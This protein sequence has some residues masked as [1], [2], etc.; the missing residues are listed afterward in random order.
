[1]DDLARPA[2][3]ERVEFR[4]VIGDDQDFIFDELDLSPILVHQSHNRPRRHLGESGKRRNDRLNRLI[5]LEGRGRKLFRARGAILRTSVRGGNQN[6]EPPDPGEPVESWRTHF[7]FLGAPAP[8]KV[9]H[10][11]PTLPGN[12]RTF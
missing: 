2:L 3:Q 6:G 12:I 9:L 8:A 7:V 5:D 1:M 4:L 10:Y 11:F